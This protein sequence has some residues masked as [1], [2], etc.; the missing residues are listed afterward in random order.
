MKRSSTRQLGRAWRV[1]PL[2][3]ALCSAGC[4]SGAMAQTTTVTMPTGIERVV[5]TATVDTS[6]SAKYL[7]NQTSRLAVWH[8]NSFNI[9]QGGRVENSAINA[10]DVTIFRVIGGNRSDIFG[11]MTANNRL[12]LINRDGIHFH[13]PDGGGPSFSGSGSFVASA[14]DLDPA[15]VANNYAG[16]QAKPGFIRFVGD[17]GQM[18]NGTYGDSIVDVD[19]GVSMVATDGGSILLVADRVRNQG[20]LTA[21]PRASGSGGSVG[22]IAAGTVE[23]LAD[24]GDSGF[25][26]MELHSAASSGNRFFRSEARVAENAGEI[27]ANQ[28]EVQII[29]ADEGF[30]SNNFQDVAPAPSI[31]A[32]VYGSEYSPGGA[33]NMGTI[34]ALSAGARQGTVVVEATGGGNAAVNSGAINVSGDAASRGGNIRMSA[35]NVLHGGDG[36]S[37]AVLRADGGTGGGNVRL[38]NSV[39]PKDGESSSLVYANGSSLISANATAAGN[40]GTITLT[41]AANKAELAHFGTVQAFGQMNALGAG[42]GAKGGTLT[43][44]GRFVS[45]RD[46]ALAPRINLGAGGLWRMVVPN[47][48]VGNTFFAGEGGSNFVNGEDISNLLN[49]GTHVT[50]Q[51]QASSLD[52]RRFEGYLTVNSDTSITRTVAGNAA[53]LKMEATGDLRVERGA[54]IIASNGVVNLTLNADAERFDTEAAPDGVGSLI[55]GEPAFVP[56]LQTQGD[57]AVLLSVPAEGPTVQI[58]TNGGNLVLGGAGTPL[59]NESEAGITSNAGVFIQNANL[60]AG[61]GTVTIEGNGGSTSGDLLSQNGVTILDSSI[62]GN[63]VN[64]TG[65]STSATGVSL[66]NVEITGGGGQ[67][68]VAGSSVN[69]GTFGQHIGVD[70]QDNVVINVGT[71]GAKLHGLA[72]GGTDSVGLRIKSLNIT[73]AALT[74]PLVTLVGQSIQTNGAGLQVLGDGDGLTLG[75]R[76]DP[77]NPNATPPLSQADIVIGA[78]ADAGA[79]ALVLGSK[80]PVF[81]TAGRINIAPMGLEINDARQ[82]YRNNAQAIRIGASNGSTNF[83]IDPRWIARTPAGGTAPAAGYVIGSSSHRGQITVADGA[84]DNAGKVSLQNQGSTEGAPRS[85][86]IVLGAQS[87]IRQLNLLTTGDISQTGPLQVGTLNIKMS[88][89]SQVALNSPGNSIQTLNFDGAPTAP[90]VTPAATT[91]S[92]DAQIAGFNTAQSAFE[93]LRIAAVATNDD[94]G[95]RH[96]DIDRSFEGTDLINELRTDVYVHGQL[97]RPQLCTPANATGHASGLRDQAADALV[98]E[99]AKVRRGPQLTSCAGMRAD[100]SCAAF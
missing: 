84:L 6:D 89:Q 100:N 40:G 94:R 4:V 18:S 60:K 42:A 15:L 25:I 46:G 16:L 99:W 83:N 82:A 39:A 70:I 9:G 86:G 8:F 33:Y 34:N 45:V 73:T 76:P 95:I 97:S 56:S 30:R 64:I 68:A 53:D 31:V 59:A 28:G 27:N 75:S 77:A 88:P 20:T 72:Y 32:D 1:R 2:I 10:S 71:G 55:I 91:N 92:G 5:G 22:L 80:A 38:D 48:N 69:T 35:A 24:V 96:D 12:F 85:Q 41:T 81:N 61:A 50:L 74:A 37:V 57:R 52:A 98:L 17:S 78:S 7:F 93:N 14:Q 79:Q 51:A 90:N 43:T 23:L 29:Q 26:K 13:R 49:A 58:D 19:P 63:A 65:G 3:L 36:E 54:R 44:M 62:A 67:V 21:T 11:T 66:N 47:L 87:G